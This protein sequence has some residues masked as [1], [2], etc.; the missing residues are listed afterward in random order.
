MAAARAGVKVARRALAA[1]LAATALACV[2]DDGTRFDP[3]P[4]RTRASTDSEREMGWEFDRK[5]QELLPLITDLEVLEFMNDLGNVMVERLGEQ[6]FDYRFRVLVDPQLNAFAVPGGYIYFHTGTILAVASVEELAGVLAHELAHVK[7]HHQA[8][9]AQETAIPN[10]LATLAGVAAGV[11]AGNAGPMIAAQGLNVALQLQYTRILEDEADRVGAIFLNRAG[12]G[13][14]GMVRFF[15]R[16]LLEKS[17]LPEQQVP[18]YLYSH[19]QVETRIDVVRQLGE[20]MAPTTTPPRLED[21]FREIQARL[22]YLVAKRRSYLG[23]VE[24]YDRARAQ[25][26][27]DSAAAQRDAGDVEGALATLVEA[28]RVEPLDPRVPLL[29]GELLAAEERPAEAIVAFR[30]AVRLDP[31]PPTVLLA[32]ARAHR[33]AGNRREA[34][35]FTEQAIW[36]SGAR[37]TLRQ[38]AERELER[39]LFPVIAESSFGDEPVPRQPGA[40]LASAPNAPR[41]ARGDEIAWWGRL[42]PHYLPWITYV[43]LRW[44][45]PS[46]EVVREKRPKRSQRVFLSDALDAAGVAPGAWRL[47]VLLGEDVVHTQPFVVTDE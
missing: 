23:D 18:A 45:D 29:R 12:W 20:K 2:Q 43:R 27:L 34:I 26:L 30:R 11:A 22:A 35:F 39:L 46:G 24:P 3:V 40:A 5:A 6:P 28:E 33:D 41:F 44:T 42:G 1:A 16:I 13:T 25:P 36:R 8:R 9:L 10:L 19:P 17:K 32:L 7:G 38:Q 14:E 37:G 15:E 31:N 21:R 4:G 47:D